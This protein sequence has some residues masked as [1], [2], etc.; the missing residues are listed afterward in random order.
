MERQQ[1]FR[2]I[3]RLRDDLLGNATNLYGAKVYMTNIGG[4][5]PNIL[6]YYLLKSDPEL[7]WA[8][9]SRW[10]DGSAQYQIDFIHGTHPDFVIAG[11]S[12]NGLTYSSIGQ[13]AED[14]TFAALWLDPDYMAIDRF[15]GQAGRTVAVFARRVAYGGWRPPISEYVP[16][17]AIVDPSG[18]QDGVR[19]SSGSL[20]YLQSYAARPV[21]ADMIIGVTGAAGQQIA[22]LVN[23][24]K[25]GN[26]VLGA[27]QRS[28]Q[29][30]V[31]LVAGWNDIVFE[32]AND[33]VV[34]FDR[35][36][37]VPHI[38]PPEPS[39]TPGLHIGSA[40][41][42]GNCSAPP[43]NA[44]AD[45]AQSCNGKAVCDYTV[46]VARLGDPAGGCSKDFAVE[47][48]CGADATPMNDN[49]PGEAGL[50]SHVTLSCPTPAA[51]AAAPPIGLSIH[52][53]TYG[54]TCGAAAGNATG[55]VRRTCSGKTDCDYIVDVARLGD[56]SQGCAKD[57]AVDYSCGA[58]ATVLH[59]AVPA[60]AGLRK[61]LKLSCSPDSAGTRP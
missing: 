8:L 59:G 27:N 35:L 26:I 53:A 24:N 9:D 48:T 36:L 34:T 11:E 61:H 12:Y 14:A 19:V 23:Q 46:D 41:Y 4:Y 25:I 13:P 29:Q 49:V 37:I 22:V 33:S 21:Q 16:S 40:T 15:Y 30:S 20:T 57:F 1:A 56:P 52:S 47:F 5:A 28:F 38:A 32:Y 39:P 3:D 54:A 51:V 45:I 55:D 60:E 58:N 10:A 43:G 17:S 2:A 31:E 44:T 18:T 7:D 42:G 50:K 6:Q